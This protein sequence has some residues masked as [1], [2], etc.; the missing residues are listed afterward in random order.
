MFKRLRTFLFALALTAAAGSATAGGTVLWPVG[1]GCAVVPAV[2]GGL[3]IG[4]TV[5]YGK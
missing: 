4:V 1:Q 2:A 5:V 3:P